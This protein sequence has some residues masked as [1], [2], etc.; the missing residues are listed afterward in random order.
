M[1]VAA[2]MAATVAAAPQA[3]AANARVTPPPSVE[4]LRKLW[5]HGTWGANIA[6]AGGNFSGYVSEA[7]YLA[8][9]RPA[10]PVPLNPAAQAEFAHIRAELA[11]GHAIFAPYAQCH[12]AGMPYQM[13]FDSYGGW[14][15]LVAQDEIVFLWGTGDFRRIYLRGHVHPNPDAKPQEP[16]DYDDP[17]PNEPTYNGDSI[18][19][20]EGRTMVVDTTNIR[21]DNSVVE[22]DIPKG[23]GS[24]IVERYTPVSPGKFAVE[25]TMT[26]PRFTRPWVVKFDINRNP[27]GVLIEHHCT[28]GN[29][30]QMM[31]GEGLV[32]SGNNGRPLEKAEE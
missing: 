18:A 29:R 32:M 9:Q 10:N 19:H 14:Q 5:E 13:A 16:Y 25:M 7:Q 27:R 15:V 8:G 24:R 17:L 3:S 21:G 30:W 20:W 23:P 28:D 6:H 12:P 31:P 4:A 2:A 11:K 26:N 1:I 22:P